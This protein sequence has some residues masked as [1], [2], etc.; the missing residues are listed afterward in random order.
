MKRA[1]LLF[2]FLLVPLD[3]LFLVAAGFGAYYARF[4]PWFTNIRPVQFEL[5]LTQY[6][7]V[8]VVVSLVWILV[9]A[10]SGLYR[11]SRP[12]IWNEVIK[13]FL[14]C[15]AGVAVILGI[16]F[17]SREL[18]ESRFI[19][20]AFWFF[21]VIFV[22][23]ERMLVRG[24]QRSL[25]RMGVGVRYVAIIGPEKTN[26]IMKEG[27]S[28]K[29]SLGYQVVYVANSFSDEVKTD[30]LELKEQRQLDGVFL[31]DP[32]AK[33]TLAQDV[34][35]FSETEQVQFFYSADFFSAAAS[36][37]VIHTYSGMPIVE[38]KKTP[39]DGWGAIYKRLF[40]IAISFI[41][42]VATLPLQILIAA[43]LFIEQPG[44][45][46]FSRLPNGSKTVRVGEG[47]YSFHYFKFRSMVKNAHSFRFDPEFIEKHGNMRDGTP[48]FKLKDDP[49]VTRVGKFIRKFSLDEIPEFYL[50]FIG[51]MSL[52]GP[53]PH[54]PEEVKKYKPHQ[55]RVLTIKPGITGMAQI[56]GRADLDFDEEVRLDTY[57]IE[58]W[59]PLMDLYI[60]LR[61]PFIVLFRKGAY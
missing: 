23:F 50:V 38:V 55:K 37:S 3:F 6:V 34:L 35:V 9:F 1:E 21:A 18:F 14:A 2:T 25:L 11:I 44:R 22:T 33:K 28:S 51:R 40:D 61:T 29:P 42:I 54:L 19:I 17:F 58:K 30:L 36:R 60:L 41:L 12:R 52:V 39:L 48:L 31:S 16:L 5:S 43:A 46:L 7:S 10:L 27:F 20:L 24:L 4:H 47:G 57:Y 32:N 8:L 26:S 45:I 56:S 53:R 13:V 49:R 15:S 59:S